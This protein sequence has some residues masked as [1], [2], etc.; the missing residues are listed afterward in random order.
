MSTDTYD[1]T[2]RRAS[3]D[4]RRHLFGSTQALV[5][6]VCEC[7]RD[8]CYQTVKLSAAEFDETRPANLIAVSHSPVAA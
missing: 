6:F 7:E 3:N 2:Q 1:Q 5:A 8:A 4:G